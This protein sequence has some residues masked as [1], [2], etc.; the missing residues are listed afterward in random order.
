M[1]VPTLTTVGPTN[2]SHAIASALVHMGLSSFIADDEAAYVALGAFL[3]QNLPVLAQLRA[4]MRERFASSLLGYP[5]LAS[6]GLEHAL[7][8]MWQRWCAG[9]PPAPF[10][11]RLSDLALDGEPETA[12]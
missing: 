5:G 11:V 3:S 4:G 7:R 2:P 8:Q 1:G 10:K 9:L 6:A 12:A